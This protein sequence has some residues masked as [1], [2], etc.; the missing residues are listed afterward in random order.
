MPDVGDF[1]LDRTENPHPRMLAGALACRDLYRQAQAGDPLDTGRL[2]VTLAR[3]RGYLAAMSD[4]T[5][6]TPE[7]IEAWM[8]RAVPRDVE[9]PEGA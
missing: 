9:R 6:E 4:A 1:V 3:W 2:M 7:A 8:D 5:G